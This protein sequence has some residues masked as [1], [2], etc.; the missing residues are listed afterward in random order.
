MKNL[1]NNSATFLIRC[2]LSANFLTG[3]GL[4]FSLIAGVLIYE[5]LFL[6]AA[7]ALLICGLL[8]L[9]D[10]AVARVSRKSTL[11]GGILDSTL[12]RY[13][14]AFI[15]GGAIFLCFK[16]YYTFWAFATFLTL[17]GSFA[18]SYIRARAECDVDECRVG[19]WERGERIACLFFGLLVNNLSIAI[20]ILLI[21]VQWTA[22]RRLYYAYAESTKRSA[23]ESFFGKLM[24]QPLKRDEWIY[25]VKGISLAFLMIFLRGP[26]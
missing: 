6:S 11:F 8:D 3:L 18:I 15:F 5:G 9:L 13:G 23:Q 12:D 1:K 25:Y 19:F 17:I 14:D 20:I 26:F 21:G 4:F 10:G 22:F 16:N 2:G 7:L 24:K